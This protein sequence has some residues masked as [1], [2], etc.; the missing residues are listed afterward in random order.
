MR[1]RRGCEGREGGCDEVGEAVMK[2]RGGC[3][4]RG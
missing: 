4:E 3:D 2:E 1:G